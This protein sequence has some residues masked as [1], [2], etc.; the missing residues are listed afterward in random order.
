M[1]SEWGVC[2]SGEC[3]WG[4]CVSGECE[5]GVCVSGECVSVQCIV[6]VTVCTSSS[7]DVD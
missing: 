7:K 5:W 2:V 4:V 1:G 6:C 3:E